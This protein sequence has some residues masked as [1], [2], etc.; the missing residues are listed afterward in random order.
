MS[1]VTR[2]TS[3]GDNRVDDA[4]L[5][6][7][8]VGPTSDMLEKGPMIPAEWVRYLEIQHVYSH[9]SS[10]C[11]LAETQI[12]QTLSCNITNITTCY[13]VTCFLKLLA[14]GK[15][16]MCNKSAR[17]GHRGG[18]RFSPFVVCLHSEAL[19]F[20]PVDLR[21]SKLACDMSTTFYNHWMFRRAGVDKDIQ[22]PLPIGSMVLL[23]GNMDPI[24]IPLMLAYMP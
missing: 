9:P 12:F 23:Y 3:P 22:R 6:Y 2:I 18:M 24:N 17:S 8:L 13:N 16:K 15:R 10:H 1:S 5:R 21:R 14:Q 7:L 4:E 19:R 20:S 11:L